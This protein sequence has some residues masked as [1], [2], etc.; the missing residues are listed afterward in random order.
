M[1]DKNLLFIHIPKT[2]GKTVNRFMAE[3]LPPGHGIDFIENYDYAD[4]PFFL[5]Y[6][7]YAGHL[8]LAQVLPLIPRADF[9]IFTFLRDPAAQLLSH[10]AW[11]K[12][13]TRAGAKPDPAE[14]DEYHLQLFANIS[15]LDLTSPAAVEK[16]V[17][18]NTRYL[19]LF[20][21]QQTRFLL[22]DVR[23]TTLTASDAEAALKTL[24]KFDFVGVTDRMEQ[25]LGAIAAANGL[26][27]PKVISVENKNPWRAEHGLARID[28][29]VRKAL[30]PWTK[31]DAL[32][33]DAARGF[34]S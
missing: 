8:R 28:P 26:T 2:G 7:Y 25:G 34:K 6:R 10:L 20:D 14:W 22:D 32:V 18:T 27:P 1:G 31:Y 15:A 3:C 13:K 24:Q 33:Y 17:A 30:E 19:R 4:K 9:Y 11:A 12:N 16:F 23:E 29:A 21:N 5:S